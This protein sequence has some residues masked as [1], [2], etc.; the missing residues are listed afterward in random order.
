MTLSLNITIAGALLLALG[1][2]HAVLPVAL[3][4]RAELATV[5]RLNREVSYVHCFFIGLACLLWGLLAL[6]AGHS[7]VEPGPVTRIVLAGAVIFW[8][9]RLVIQLLVFNRHARRSASWCALSVAGTGLWAYLTLVWC[10]VLAAQ[11]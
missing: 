2:L 3:Q 7:L 10:W 5:S 6:T 8:S 4:W 11:R 9:A 1:A